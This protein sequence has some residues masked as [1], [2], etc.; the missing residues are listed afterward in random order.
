[1]ADKVLIA[2]KHSKTYQKDTKPQKL[3]V[4]KRRNRLILKIGRVDSV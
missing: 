2:L 3:V 1:M 4:F